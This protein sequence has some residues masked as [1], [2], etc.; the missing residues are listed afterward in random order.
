[1]GKLQKAIDHD[2]LVLY[3]NILSPVGFYVS[4]AYDYLGVEHM[5]YEL[6]FGASEHKSKTYMSKV[7][8]RGQIPAIK[9]KD[10]PLNEGTATV[11]YGGIRSIM[12]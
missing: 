9:D 4:A 2:G 10:F 6:N 3:T 8:P 1:M 7:N 12:I 5:K 11:K